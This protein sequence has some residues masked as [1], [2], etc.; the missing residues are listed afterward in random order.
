MISYRYEGIVDNFADYTYHILGC[1]AIGSSA[2][3]QITRMGG[4][5]F[6]LYD[7]DIVSDE[8]IGVSMYRDNQVGENKVN[9]L[10]TLIK[11]ISPSIEVSLYHKLFEDYYPE[12][13]DI[14]VLGF[15][16]MKARFDAMETIL[17]TKQPDYVID[18]RMGAEHYQQY[19]IFK[20]TIMKYSKTWYSDEDGSPE[21]CNAK[22]TSYCSNMAGSFIS[23]T[24][25]KICSKQPYHGNISFNFPTMTLEK[26]GY[27]S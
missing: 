16:S 3:T 2:A 18:G 21:P 24:I 26:S 11:E 13:A 12:G 22:A 27:I 5:N 4:R 20:P 25:R 10:Y 6:K 7:M 19:T 8:N 1:G 23:N 17:R 15:D 9:A 14:I